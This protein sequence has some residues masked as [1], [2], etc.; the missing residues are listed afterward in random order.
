MSSTSRGVDLE[1]RVFSFFEAEIKAGRFLARPECCAI[2]HRKAYYSRD[3]LSDIFFDVAIELTLPGADIP[4]ALW[5]IECKDYNHPVPVDDVEEFFTKVQQVAAA[6]S[7]AILVTSN[8]F[9]RG[10]LEFARSK[11]IGL[12]RVF[13]TSEF[14]WVL[15]RSPSSLHMSRSLSQDDDVLMGLTQEHYH[16]RR[17]DF[18]CNVGDLFTYSLHDFFLAL[19]S[20]AFD[21]TSLHAIVAERNDPDLVAFMSGDEIEDQCRAV[22]SAIR[23]KGGAVSLEAVCEWQKLEAGLTVVTGVAASREEAER[24]I[25]GRISFKPPSITV[26]FDPMDVLRRRF[27]LAHELGHLL[28]GH[29]AY[30]QAESVD[31]QDIESG[32]Y[33][34]LGVDDIRRLEWQA[35]YF[36][37]CLLLPRDWFV[38]SAFEKARQMDLKDRGHGLIFLD[39]QPINTHNYYVLTSALMAAYKVSRTAVSIRLKSLGL[40]NESWMRSE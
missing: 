2:F 4:S 15:H 19:T 7:K 11:G 22:H 18:F 31:E 3:R 32:D 12:L 38:A 25:L 9:Q 36:A 8:S 39:H 14:K 17:F 6:K 33:T 27:T 35:N 29:G 30:M 34:D 40:L 21:T 13:P 5:L 20:D 28:L 24:G 23:Y 10:A 37:S 16:S 26:F 1:E